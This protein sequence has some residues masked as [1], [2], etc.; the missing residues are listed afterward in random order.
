MPKLRLV[1]PPLPLASQYCQYCLCICSVPSQY[2]LAIFSFF[3]HRTSPPRRPT[4]VAR[5]GGSGGGRFNLPF[6]W[7]VPNPKPQTAVCCLWY[8]VYCLC[9]AVL[10]ATLL[11]PVR[12]VAR[13]AVLALDLLAVVH[14]VA[15]AAVL[16][17]A[18]LAP[19]RGRTSVGPFSQ[20][21]CTYYCKT[22]SSSCP[23]LHCR[24]RLC[25]CRSNG[26]T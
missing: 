11:A 10:A 8:V 25:T 7:A 15:R 16:A 17:H 14:A 22:R 4:P 21:P 24:L 26:C 3:A 20:P 23:C 13:A 2:R 6:G 19:V 1:P 18:L 9:T 12:A 5:S